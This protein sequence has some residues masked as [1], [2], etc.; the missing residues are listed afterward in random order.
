MIS[1]NPR[2]QRVELIQA[3][4]L[5]LPTY[6]LNEQRKVQFMNDDDG[7]GDAVRQHYS[8]RGNI[9]TRKKEERKKDV[10]R[11]KTIDCLSPISSSFIHRC[12]FVCLCIRPSLFVYSTHLLLSLS[13]KSLFCRV[14][15]YCPNTMV[16]FCMSFLLFPSFFLP[17]LS[18]CLRPLRRGGETHFFGVVLF[19][20]YI[21]SL[22]VSLLTG[23]RDHR[24]S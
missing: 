17:S 15:I 23:S 12:V 14:A 5:A 18:P 9:M 22:C 20:N 6:Y 8:L 10:H 24:E 11:G 16:Q 2:Q 1:G 13:R 7:Q 3:G 21:M 19:P 4:L